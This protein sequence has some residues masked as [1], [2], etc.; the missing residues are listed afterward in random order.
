MA[1][2]HLEA[3]VADELSLTLRRERRRRESCV[4][5]SP[6]L[7]KPPRPLCSSVKR[8]IMLR[9][10]RLGGDSLTLSRAAR[11]RERR[12]VPISEPHSVM[13]AHS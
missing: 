7:S 8:W 10:V 13:A 4:L 2:A 12:G 1:L 5:S 9:R 3:W 6:M 11:A